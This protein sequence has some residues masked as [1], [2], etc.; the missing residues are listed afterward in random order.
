M[1]PTSTFYF[2]I[3]YLPLIYK[4]LSLA[5]FSTSLQIRFLSQ[6]T[7][8]ITRSRFRTKSQKSVFIYQITI[9]TLSTS[10]IAVLPYPLTYNPTQTQINKKD[11]LII[12]ST[13][14]ITSIIPNRNIILVPLPSNLRIM[15]QRHKIL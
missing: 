2:F 9:P 13:M 11:S 6:T 15:I 8:S 12:S 1:T 14:P 10:L 3:Q 5:Y 7:N 4:I